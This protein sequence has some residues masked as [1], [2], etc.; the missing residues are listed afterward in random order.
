MGRKPK[1]PEQ[2]M[3]FFNARASGASL[4]QAPAVANVSSATA[5]NWLEQSGGVRRRLEKPRPALRLSL[6]E[7][8]V[9]REG[10][11]HGGR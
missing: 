1:P 9:I 10:C 2:R 11:R 3:A 8:E 5:C 7:R 4:R 6:E